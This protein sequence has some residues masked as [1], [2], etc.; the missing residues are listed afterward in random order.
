MFLVRQEDRVGIVDFDGNILIPI[1]YVA[2][3][4]PISDYMFG[5]IE[6]LNHLCNVEFFI[7][8]GD[9]FSIDKVVTQ[10]ELSIVLKDMYNGLYNIQSVEKETSPESITVI[11]SSIF[12]K[13]FAL[14]IIEKP[15]NNCKFY[16]YEKYW[17]SNHILL[18]LQ[19]PRENFYAGDKNDDYDLEDTWNA[20]TDGMYDDMPDGFDGDFGFMGH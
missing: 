18:D 19:D 17:F 12:D 1:E 13:E 14:K 16:T 15:K 7:K 5:V 3:T 9:R 4:Y 10:N 11:N 20:M 8:K 2:I 6:T